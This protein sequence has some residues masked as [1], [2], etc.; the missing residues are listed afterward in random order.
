MKAECKH[1]VLPEHKMTQPSQ[2][3]VIRKIPIFTL[4]MLRHLAFQCLTSRDY[5][6]I[7]V[8]LPGTLREI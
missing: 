4:A 7:R 8:H 3:P 1:T 6:I 2:S 5:T